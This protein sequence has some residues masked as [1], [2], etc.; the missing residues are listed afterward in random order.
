MIHNIQKQHCIWPQD[1]P[2]GAQANIKPSRLDKVI[3][4][5]PQSSCLFKMFVYEQ[6]LI[7]RSDLEQCVANEITALSIWPEVGHYYLVYKQK[8]QW[9]VVVW[10]WDASLLH[11]DLA[12]TH[13]VPALAY[14]LGRLQHKPALLL[15]GEANDSWACYLTA[16]GS[17]S[18]VVP[19]SSRI[20]R[21]KVQLE[22]N[23]GQ[24][25]LYKAGQFSDQHLLELINPP[26]DSDPFASQLAQPKNPVLDAGRIA[27]LFDFN[28]PWRFYRQMGMILAG[29]LLFL[30]LDYSLISLKESGIEQQRNTLS[31][32]T[33]DLVSQ[34]S[35]KQDMERVLGELNVA[36]ASQ[37]RIALL[38]E[39]MT[40]TL[41]KD[42][43]LNQLSFRNNKI[44]LQGE[45]ADSVALLER[46]S[47]LP[48]V[49]QA[50]FIGDITPNSDGRQTFR[51]EMQL[52]STAEFASQTL[53]KASE[54]VALK[55]DLASV[56][57]PELTTKENGELISET[58]ATS[59]PA[60]D[61]TTDSAIATTIEA[62][63]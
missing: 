16:S 34:R 2:N 12:I 51:A 33:Q 41:E 60:S 40:Q 49:T 63:E 58:T 42:V 3:G 61:T 27:S 47:S 23:G 62:A 8:E 7:G 5:V 22:L 30:V 36:F 29:L 26:D 28:S 31:L 4:L 10:L 43:V 20:H 19:L 46:L 21:H 17:I 48:G 13:L 50:R 56:S 44:E 38:I 37:Q 11:Y 59:E 15:Y 55:S 35:Q 39:A 14:E 25:T 45:V 54:P 53:A 57:A 6:D 1:W 24:Y 52:L 18:S 9:Q 32:S